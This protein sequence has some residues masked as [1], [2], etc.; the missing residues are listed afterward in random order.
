MKLRDGF[1]L[2][3]M[4]EEFVLVP[5]GKAAEKFHGIVKLNGTAAFIVRQLQS[6]TDADRIVDAI[7]AEYEGTREQFAA[8]VD[9]TLAQLRGIDALCE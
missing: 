9:S 1:I 7:A 3:P 5:T 4:G 2:T 8:A 6:E